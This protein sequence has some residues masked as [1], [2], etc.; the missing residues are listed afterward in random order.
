MTGEIDL[1]IEGLSDYR[2]IGSGGFGSVY[3]AFEAGQGRR[4]AVKVLSAVD[5]TGRRRFDRERLTMGQ[6]TDHQNI[7]TLFRSGYTPQ[8]DQPY[9]LMEYLSGGSL[10]DR[11]EA[12][13]PLR[14]S[15]AIEVGVAVADAL[16]FSHRVGIVH[17]DVKPANILVSG[18]GTV[19]LTD[20]GIAA[21][22]EATA[23]SVVSYSLAFTPPE[24]FIASRDPVTG[25]VVDPRDER[26]DLY[27]LAATVYALGVGAPPFQHPTQAGLF[28]QI[29]REPVA[30]TGHHPL[31]QVL[32]RAMA[33]EPDDRFGTADELGAALAALNQPAPSAG[34]VPS[35]VAVDPGLATDGHQ[36]L[37]GP[38]P[39]PPT[40]QVASPRRAGSGRTTRMVLVGLGVLAL[41]GIAALG[42]LLTAGDDPDT[43]AGATDS[44]QDSADPGTPTA[45]TS[46]STSVD[47]AIGPT[48]GTEPTSTA[49]DGPEPSGPE[50][51]DGP[52]VFAAH[53]GQVKAVATL[54]DGRIAS[55]GDD[56][57][58]QVWD[59]DDPT[60]EPVV[61]RRHVNSVLGV[62]ALA[63][64]RIASGSL[65]STVLVWDPADPS[66]EPIAFT[67]HTDAVPAIAVLPDGRIASGSWDRTVRIWDP[68]DGSVVPVVYRGHGGHVLALEVLDDGRIA[69]GSDDGTVQVWDPD[70]PSAS[71][72]VFVVES[73][74]YAL[75]VGSGGRIVAGGTTGLVNVW[76]LGDPSAA[77]IVFGDHTDEVLA[78]GVLAD[79]RVASGSADTTVRIWDPDD[80]ST[81]P[82][83]F[84]EHTDHTFAVTVL[85]DGRIASGSFDGTVRVW[86]PEEP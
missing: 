3:S 14:W 54:D 76:D 64:G 7:V 61:F 57:T 85:A 32:A 12:S 1:G 22:K 10:Q 43:V 30:A 4:V 58:V 5:A 51:A 31:D 49:P 82:L 25:E 63:D 83:V 74:V 23:T 48:A 8:G 40:P 34:P 71:P 55:G 29:L 33:K 86:D 11:L 26:S 60:S 68:D 56:G 70:D 21:V 77:P 84:T 65:D 24:T 6:T 36:T 53:G 28:A 41:A 13:G 59:P 66:A 73:G 17:K 69:S 27:S 44:V 78:V 52:V 80:L 38:A 72:V 50:D 37:T 45:S 67:D 47:P 20:F 9:L 46:A 79:G 39:L 19:K 2:E 15:E 35:P 18:T 75:A 16:A 81:E 62:A 42:L